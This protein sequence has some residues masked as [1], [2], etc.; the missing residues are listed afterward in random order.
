LP[1]SRRCFH[2]AARKGWHNESEP[3]ILFTGHVGA[4]S[5]GKKLLD[6]GRAQFQRWNVHPRFSDNLRLV[7]RLPS[8]SRGISRLG[9]RGSARGSCL[10]HRSRCESNGE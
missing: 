2:P 8:A 3:T 7:D 6:S 10:R 1:C 5:T 4:D 9:A